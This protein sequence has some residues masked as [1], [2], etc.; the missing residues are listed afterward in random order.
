MAGHVGSVP[1]AGVQLASSTAALAVTVNTVKVNTC[2][3]R[4]MVNQMPD[5]ILTRV[6]NFDQ[7]T[8][9]KDT[10]DKTYRSNQTC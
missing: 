9:T 4:H 10:V 1:Q 7:V 3:V 8:N 5:T 2:I 6:E